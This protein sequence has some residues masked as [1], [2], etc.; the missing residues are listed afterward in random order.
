MKQKGREGFRSAAQPYPDWG[1]V[2][3]T[4][5]SET[6]WFWMVRYIWKSLH[7]L[8]GLA[9]RMPARYLQTPAEQWHC[10]QGRPMLSRW[11]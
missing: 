5:F 10:P 6:L 1:K 7:A 9:V 3:K 8:G 4:S 2:G 11:G